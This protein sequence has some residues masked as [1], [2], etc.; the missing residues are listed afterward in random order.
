MEHKPPTIEIKLPERFSIQ[1][2]IWLN[3]LL[4]AAQQD[5]DVTDNVATLIARHLGILDELS[6]LD[7]YVH[8]EMRDAVNTIRSMQRENAF[9]VQ[10]T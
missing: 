7:D 10:D 4:D 9:P 2:Q 6:A 8:V 1:A 5:I 3:I